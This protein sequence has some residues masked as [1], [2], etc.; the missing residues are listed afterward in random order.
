MHPIL[1]VFP[2]GLLSTSV[3]FDVLFML[4]GNSAFPTVSYWMIAAGI[5]GGLVAAS[6]G[7]IDWFGI[8][9][10]TRAKRIGLIH[11]LVNVGLLVLFA[12]SFYFRHFMGV[13]PGSIPLA[14]SFIAFGL[15]LIGGW[16]G[17]ELVERLAIAVHTGA[18]PDA[19]SSLTTDTADPTMSPKQQEVLS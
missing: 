11:G 3:I 9:K 19:P 8:P 7:W 4:F 6:T 5:I 18:H 10:G 14:L 16:L 12:A 15:A 2:L 1:I 17:G 13:V